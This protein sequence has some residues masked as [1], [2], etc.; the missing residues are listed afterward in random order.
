MLHPQHFKPQLLLV[1]PREKEEERRE[2]E[3][4]GS[5]GLGRADSSQVSAPRH[6]RGTSCS[7]TPRERVPGR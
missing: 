4:L 7:H 2:R 5:Q 3:F 1:C 6:P